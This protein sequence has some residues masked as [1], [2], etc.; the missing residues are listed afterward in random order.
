VHGLRAMATGRWLL[1]AGAAAC[2]SS[3]AMRAAES[4]DRATLCQAIAAREL[5]GSLSNREAASLARAVATNDLKTASPMN[6]VA[7]VGDVQPCARE[8][9]GA[10]SARM[11]THDDAGAAAALA[12]LDA[13]GWDLDDARQY[14]GDPDPAWRAVGTRALIRATDRRARLAALVDGS[15]LVRRE[16]A[17]AARD[18]VD[19]ADLRPLSDAARLDPEPIVRT[20]AVRAMAAF[21][22]GEVADALRDLWAGGDDGLREDIALAWSSPFLWSTGGRDALR[23]LVASG[24]GPG[25]IE[26]AAAIL[27][28]HDAG[29]ELAAL[30]VG[31]LVQAIRSG[32]RV[33]RLQAIAQASLDRPE[34]IDAVRAC[35]GDDDLEVRIGALTRL[36]GRAAGGAVD[37]RTA[38]EAGSATSALEALARPE[39]PDGPQARF[40]LGGALRGTGDRRIQARLEHHLVSA[41]P[42]ERLGAAT[43]LANLGVAARAATLL[44]DDDP[45]VRDRAAC[46]LMMANRR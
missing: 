33:T 23:G 24:H 43:A 41:S 1:F 16:A 31:R 7:R 18:A 8:L 14:A 22:G 15:P 20:E 40:A 46:T 34:L 3:V 39:S 30:A 35:A 10:L 4:G 5:R 21:S 26:G 25:A 13:R 19:P 36:A 2:S 42:A 11:G 29:P 27:R 45:S 9:D 37:T 28:H 32:A 44:A 6:A 17:R 38:A 12:R